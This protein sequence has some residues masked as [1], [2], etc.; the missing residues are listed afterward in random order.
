MV[1]RTSSTNSFQVDYITT[2]GSRSPISTSASGAT[3]SGLNWGGIPFEWMAIYFGGNT[4]LWPSATADPDG[5]GA[6]N[7][8]EFM[9]WTDPTNAASVLIVKLSNS[10]Q[11]M[12]LSWPTQPGLTY[13]VQMKTSLT[14][15]WSNLGAPR[16]A[17][18]VGDSIFV[19][20]TSAA[21]YR[22][23][24]LLQ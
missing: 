7:L 1:W 14:A 5:D 21:Y 19:G 20:G 13:Q 6:N 4:N 10:P 12:F 9:T 22:V 17:A 2:G 23:V 16:F 3:W 8:Q 15:A 24:V 18:G 11:G